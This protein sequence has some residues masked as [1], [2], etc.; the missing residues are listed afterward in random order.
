MINEDYK[1]RLKEVQF[2]YLVQ[3]AKK[4]SLDDESKALRCLINFAMQETQHESS[5]FEEIRCLDC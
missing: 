3:M 2:Q 5:I 4:Y 1:V